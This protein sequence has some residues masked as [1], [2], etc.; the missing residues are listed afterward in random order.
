MDGAEGGDFRADAAVRT[1]GGGGWP[2]ALNA[3][4]FGEGVEAL[5]DGQITI[6]GEGQLAGFLEGFFS[7]LGFSTG[8]QD[9]RFDGETDKVLGEVFGEFGGLDFV[10]EFEPVAGET[11]FGDIEWFEV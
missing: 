9:F 11:L 1:L 2:V 6:Q 3:E 10:V 4:G 7:L 8:L 5:G